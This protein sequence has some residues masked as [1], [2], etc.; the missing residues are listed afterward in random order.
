[1][2]TLTRSL[3]LHFQVHSDNS[4]WFTVITLHVH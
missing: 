3:R 2:K 4:H 1:M